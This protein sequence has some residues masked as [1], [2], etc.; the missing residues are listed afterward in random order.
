M[1]MLQLPLEGTAEDYVPG[2]SQIIMVVKNVDPLKPEVQFF[3]ARCVKDGWNPFDIDLSTV[4]GGKEEDVRIR[5]VLL[6]DN[7][8]FMTGQEDVTAGC[9]VSQKYLRRISP[10]TTKPV[11]D[12]EFLVCP[13]S[14]E[15]PELHFNLGLVAS[16]T[17]LDCNDKPVQWSVPIVIDPKITNME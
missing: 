2:K 12:V 8:T 5:V 1:S 14:P 17:V 9:Q 10:S 7:L 6:Q 16:G 13:L 4:T 15:G 3:P 11:K